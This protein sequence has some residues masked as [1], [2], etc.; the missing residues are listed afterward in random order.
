MTA[1]APGPASAAS[2]SPGALRA[3]VLRRLGPG[4]PGPGFAAPVLVG[5]RDFDGWHL[6]DL[7]FAAAAGDGSA[8]ETIPALFLR[9]PEGHAPVPGL[10]YIHAHGNRYET[11]RDELT[12]GRPALR[13][14]YAGDLRRLGIATL[15]LDLPAFGARR[16][17]GEGARAKA[18]LWQGRT[19]FGQML[20]EL[21][22]AV[23]FLAAQPQVRADRIGAMG[24]SMGS[25]LAWW[26]AALDPRIRAAS[27]L[28]SFADLGHLL[29]SGAHD[30]HG[31]YMTVPGLAAV[32]RSGQIAGL[33][34]PRALLVGVGLQDWST[35]AEAFATARADLEAAYAAAGATERLR[36]LVE[37]ESGHVETPAMRAAVRDFLARA[38]T[39]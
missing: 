18:A 14:P 22:A 36:I 23:G 11:G 28:C 34:A 33:A 3:E 31:I 4:Y 20:A 19:L 32:A 24:F 30:G 8:P 15:C 6:D 17:P 9:P 27:A 2:L 39:G 12:D 21:S 35:P 25:T 10:V 16:D 1:S 29:A 26:L 7:R 38:L 13:G 5:R 37:P